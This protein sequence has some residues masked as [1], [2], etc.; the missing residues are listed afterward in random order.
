[1]NLW[2]SMYVE[3]AGGEKNPSYAEIDELAKQSFVLM[4]HY[5]NK[6]TKL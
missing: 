2:V 5:I 1:M 4:I 3:G 6:F